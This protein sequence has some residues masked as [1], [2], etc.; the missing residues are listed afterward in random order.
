MILGLD[1]S[2][3]V[4]GTAVLDENDLKLHELSYISLKKE[5]GL[6][7]KALAF[8]D[9]LEKYDGIIDHVAIEE[10]LV[11]FKE[12]FSMAQILAMLSQFNGM[13][14]MLTYF[15]YN[16]EPVLYNVNTARKLAIPEMKFPKGSDRKSVVLENVARLYPDVDWPLGPRSG[17][18]KKECF[19][20]ADSA[21]IALAHA[22][23]LRG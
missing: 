14:Q 3:S 8:K 9:E 18:L 1:I 17:K 22:K 11:M 13:C 2:T 7:N 16:Q 19:D 10:P 12:G 15:L 23:T 6:F 20:M 21:I 5:K 4:I